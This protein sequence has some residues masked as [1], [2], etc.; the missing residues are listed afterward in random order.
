MANRHGAIVGKAA[1]LCRAVLA[2]IRRRY[3]ARFEI[4]GHPQP[5]LVAFE[6]DPDGWIAVTAFAPDTLDN[7]EESRL[8]VRLYQ[9][10]SLPPEKK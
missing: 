5:A 3:I 6:D 2:N 1:H 4:E 10:A 9:R 7:V 8:G